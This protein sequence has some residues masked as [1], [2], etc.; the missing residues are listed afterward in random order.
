MLAL[1]TCTQNLSL[2]AEGYAVPGESG[3]GGRPFPNRSMPVILSQIGSLILALGKVGAQK[4]CNS[5]VCLTPVRS[6]LKFNAF[7]TLHQIT[8]GGAKRPR[9][10]QVGHDRYSAT[11]ASFAVGLAHNLTCS[12]GYAR[13]VLS[14][15]PFDLRGAA[16]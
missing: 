7:N 4:W 2:A 12:A 6:N 5:A 8:T 13:L 11:E 16:S 10:L 14:H 1:E 15:P 9:M 3:V